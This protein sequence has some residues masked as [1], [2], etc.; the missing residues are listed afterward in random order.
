MQVCFTVL[1]SE[2]Y[3][4]WSRL[5]IWDFFKVSGEILKEYQETYSSYLVGAW[6]FAKCFCV[7]KR[8]CWQQLEKQ[9][10]G[11]RIRQTWVFVM[12]LP[13][14]LCCLK[15][16]PYPPQVSVSPSVQWGCECYSLCSLHKTLVR[17]QIAN[18]VKCLRS[19]MSGSCGVN[20]FI[21][22]TNIIKL[23]CCD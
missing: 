17:T 22:F 16:V 3:M 6:Q 8:C 13:L 23:S 14:I 5:L 21:H 12:A 1:Y 19:I 18:M 2:N 4:L 15:W 10:D 20:S 9:R 11:Q 7:L